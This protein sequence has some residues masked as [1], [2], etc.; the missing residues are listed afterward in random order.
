VLGL[1]E[2]GI[3]VLR[4]EETLAN[5]EDFGRDVTTWSVLNYS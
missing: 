5:D 4:G 2:F 1:E 3:D